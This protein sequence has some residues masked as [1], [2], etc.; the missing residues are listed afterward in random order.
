MGAIYPFLDIDDEALHFW[1]HKEE[2][3]V[4]DEVAKE[5]FGAPLKK[6]SIGRAFGL[7]K[8]LALPKYTE[9]LN[10]LLFVNTGE[11]V[12]GKLTEQAKATG[13]MVLNVFTVDPE[14]DYMVPLEEIEFKSEARIAADKIIAEVLSEQS[15]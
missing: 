12:D 8:I 6:L 13:R 9:I 10:D 1:L 2:Y 11:S 15:A 4:V 7:M 5:R 14:T 3:Q